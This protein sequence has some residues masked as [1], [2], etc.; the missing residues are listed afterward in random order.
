MTKGAL[1]NPSPLTPDQLAEI[2]GLLARNRLRVVQKDLRK[3][4]LF[5]DQAFDA[6]A[7]LQNIRSNKVRYDIAYNAA[8]DVGEALLAA[9][10]Y[11]TISGTGQHAAIGEFLEVIF[12]GR[13]AMDASSDFD[14]IRDGRNGLRYQ[15]KSIGKAQTEFA[16]ATAQALLDHA[17]IILK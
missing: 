1:M 9:Y 16:I 6:L 13:L 7:E 15:A 2:R 3:A 17:Q 12:E 11:R 8:H 14:S 4:R 10:G 5:I